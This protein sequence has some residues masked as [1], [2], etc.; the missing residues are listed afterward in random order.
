MN[1]VELSHPLPLA[2][3]YSLWTRPT[4]SI[5]LYLYKDRIIAETSTSKQYPDIVT[6]LI[7]CL[8][9]MSRPIL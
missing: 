1:M 6:I 9:D 4:C 2:M 7:H 3:V 5:S 8:N